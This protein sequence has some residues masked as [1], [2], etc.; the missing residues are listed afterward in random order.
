MENQE[1]ETR[2]VSMESLDLL[3]SFIPLGRNPDCFVFVF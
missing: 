1:L 3:P 2:Q